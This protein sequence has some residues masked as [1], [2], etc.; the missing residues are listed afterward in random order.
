MIVNMG[1]PQVR[2]NNTSENDDTA[3]IKE[4]PPYV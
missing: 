3:H 1:D 4:I 2:E